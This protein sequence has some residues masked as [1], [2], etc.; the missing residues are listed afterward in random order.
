GSGAW[1]LPRFKHDMHLVAI[2]TGPGVR[3]LYWPIAKPYQPMSP[4]VERRVIGS[5]GAVWLDADGDGQRTSAFDYAQRL[6]HASGKDLS[7]LVRQLGDYDEAVAAQ[8]ASLL[9][10]RG[11]SLQDPQLREAVRTAGAQVER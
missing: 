11:V 4:N 9:Q 3:E 6:L 10:R 7:K 8:A 5:T 2:A 1:T